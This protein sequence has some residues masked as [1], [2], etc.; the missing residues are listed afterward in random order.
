MNPY[1]E[2][3]NWIP[4]AKRLEIQREAERE[5]K[6]QAQ[7]KRV[8]RMNPSKRAE[9]V[10][11]FIESRWRYPI[12][13]YQ[14]EF[15]SNFLLPEIDVVGFSAARASLKTTTCAGITT[16]MLHPDG[17]LHLPN[18]E[19][20]VFLSAPT[21]EEGEPFHTDVVE[22]L[23]CEKL[24]KSHGYDSNGWKI[25]DS[26][27]NFGVK[28]E[29][30]SF[31][32]IYGS[33][34]KSGK[35]AQAWFLDEIIQFK[36][37]PERCFQQ[38]KTTLGKVKGDTL[39]VLSTMDESEYHFFSELMYGDAPG[40]YA[41]LFQADPKNP[42][43]SWQQANPALPHSPDIDKVLL[44]LERA[45]L[46]HKEMQSFLSLRCNLGVADAIP[47]LA[48][49]VHSGEWDALPTTPNTPPEGEKLLAVGLDLGM[50]ES[51][52]AACAVFESGRI[53]THVFCG[54]NPSL[55]VRE[56]RD[57]C[58]GL[59]RK[60]EELGELTQ[61][62]ELRVPPYRQVLLWIKENW[63]D[64]LVICSD[65][66]WKSYVQDIAQEVGFLDLFVF[67]DR[68]QQSDDIDAL[69][70][71]IE[72][73]HFTKCNSI[74]LD[75]AIRKSYT[76]TSP[77]G[78]HSQVKASRRGSRNDVTS[79]LLRAWRQYLILADTYKPPSTEIL[80]GGGKLQW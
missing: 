80:V 49:L 75:H 6:R 65:G 45:K 19:S 18:G 55:A 42:L 9:A 3:G 17:P 8:M 35:R 11:S 13:D 27:A 78:F 40:S 74:L 72:H 77:S 14:V 63:G 68:F 54:G 47:D 41:M 59:Y 7:A 53:V 2:N 52:S 22:M 44:H 48:A 60:A 62:P 61:F 21:I 71:S 56:E 38:A 43:D 50:S 28:H 79:A 26:P 1:D 4:R 36:Q 46:D 29:D 23:G 64:P 12:L 16:A 25:L 33:S 51:L 31:L 67:S 69:R 57:I 76:K 32:K 20:K 70:D 39:C 10:W 24:K 34:V 5:R 58:N 73:G 37:S 30:G 15:T 66:Y